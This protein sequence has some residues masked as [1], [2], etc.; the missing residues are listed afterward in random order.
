MTHKTAA[1]LAVLVLAGCGTTAN[2][3]T[4][5]ATVAPTA[6]HMVWSG[7]GMATKEPPA[8]LPLRG[9][10]NWRLTT[11]QGC[12]LTVT[13]VGLNT[14]KLGSSPGVMS[15]G[16]FNLPA[17]TYTV[18]PTDVSRFNEAGAAISGADKCVWSVDMASP[19]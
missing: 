12:Y 2:R 17:G 18:A 5:L 13:L 16:I 8:L 19:Q 3:A 11:T 6:L 1:I 7:H 9:L 14:W 15:G 10:W 4:S